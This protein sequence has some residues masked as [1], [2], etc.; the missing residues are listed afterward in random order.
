[1]IMVAPSEIQNSKRGAHNTVWSEEFERLPLKHRLKLL[2]ASNRL[3]LDS[4]VKSDKILKNCECD[5]PFLAIFG[6]WDKLELFFAAHII[7]IILLCCISI[8]LLFIFQK[9]AGFLGEFNHGKNSENRWLNSSHITASAASERAGLAESSYFQ[10]S[11]VVENPVE[12]KIECGEDSET[13]MSVEVLDKLDHVVFKERLR[14]L[15]T[16]F[17]FYLFFYFFDV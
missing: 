5:S 7:G 6:T 17:H 2:L 10:E 15:L 3:P 14:M 9:N 16:R 12:V 13:K 1:M 11:L 4:D 8:L